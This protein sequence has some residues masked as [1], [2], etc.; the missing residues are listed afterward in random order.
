MNI[1][2]FP[3]NPAP[4]H[5]Q[6]RTEDIPAPEAGRIKRG[7]AKIYNLWRPG[8]VTVALDLRDQKSKTL[9]VDA[10]REWAHHTPALR[11]H[12]VD[13]K[14]G[15]IRIS[16]DEGLKGNWSYFG[17]DAKSA[18]K[19]KPTMHLD[20]TDDSKK[21]RSSALHEF[22]HALG[23]VH[24]HQHPQNTVDWNASAAYEYYIRDSFSREQVNAQILGTL[25]GPGILATPY[26]PKSV[27]HYRIPMSL[28]NKGQ[29]IPKNTSLS[30]GDRNIAQEIYAVA[31]T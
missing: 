2:P 19:D 6:P 26:D 15:D 23:L 8:V 22:G 4:L 27:M 3:S 16:D 25:S 5:P 24:E 7:L 17:T 21:F 18:D 13:G 12:I 1:T 31:P 11:F 28:R 29:G 14:K 9:M 30:S 20:R 10:I